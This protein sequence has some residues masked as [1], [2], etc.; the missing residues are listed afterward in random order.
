VL[1]ALFTDPEF[2]NSFGAKVR[3]PGE[4]VTASMRAVGVTPNSGVASSFAS[5][6]WTLQGLGHQ[7]M[8]WHAPDGYPDTAD[9]WLSTGATLGR[10]NLHMGVL[11]GWWSDGYTLAAPASLL[12]GT[13]PASLGALVDLMTNRLL[14]VTFATAHRNALL[15]FLTASGTSTVSDVIQWRL[16]VLGALILDSPYGLQR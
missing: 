14:G 7:P 10:W 15:S 1:G 8:A 5:M 6:Y 2:L 4:D 9:A 13:T 12:G 16:D 11:G 3:R